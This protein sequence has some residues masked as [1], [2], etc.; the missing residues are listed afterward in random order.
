MSSRNVSSSSSTLW[1]PPPSLRIT[2]CCHRSTHVAC[3][4]RSSRGVV[5]A[6]KI[7]AQHSTFV[8][9][10]KDLEY[11]IACSSFLLTAVSTALLAEK[12]EK[13]EEEEEEGGGV[14][15]SSRIH[16]SSRSSP[17][18]MTRSALPLETVYSAKTTATWVGTQECST[19]QRAEWKGASLKEPGGALASSE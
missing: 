18:L 9:A 14:T 5:V 4:R 19:L 12:E 13:E 7:T 10:G 3:S 16:T 15:P 8:L 1:S 2:R 17:M 11:F 6:D